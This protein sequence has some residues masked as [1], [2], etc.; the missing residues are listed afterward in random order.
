[1]E[2]R[3]ERKVYCYGE[4]MDLIAEFPS[5]VAAARAVGGKPQGITAC[6][7]GQKK[8]YKGY[9]WKYVNPDHSR[10]RKV[11]CYDIDG[12]YITTYSSIS[13]AA[14]AVGC[15]LASIES[16]CLGKAK[17]A[18]GFIWTFENE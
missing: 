14:R 18:G 1:M 3:T 10:L 6:C 12:S 7:C 9:A 5:I 11:E 4:Y 16:C 8:R 17:T 15:S 2:K 13:G